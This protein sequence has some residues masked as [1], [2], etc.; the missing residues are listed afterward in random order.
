MGMV[1]SGRAV[2]PLLGW[3]VGA[4][5]LTPWD[6]LAGLAA[7][8]YPWLP[9]GLLLRGRYGSVAKLA[10]VPASGGGAAAAP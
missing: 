2:K 9:A 6:R 10:A 4:L 1:R 5:L 8:H 7:Y 3:V